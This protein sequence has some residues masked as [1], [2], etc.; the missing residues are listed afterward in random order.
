M[1]PEAAKQTSQQT[2]PPDLPP[3]RSQNETIWIQM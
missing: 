1:A 2:N 3:Y